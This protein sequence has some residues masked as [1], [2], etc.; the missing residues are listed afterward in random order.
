MSV[1]LSL[2]L[3]HDRLQFVVC[4][5]LT[6]RIWS[7]HAGQRSDISDADKTALHLAAEGAHAECVAQL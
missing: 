7:E 2:L 5:C 4:R 1:G 6:G 3:R